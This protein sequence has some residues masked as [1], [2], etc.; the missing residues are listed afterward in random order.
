MVAALKGKGV[1]TAD[2]Q[3]SSLDVNS[4]TSDTGH[5]AGFSVSNQVTV[6][7]RDI[8]A[9]PAVLQAAIGAGANQAGGLRYFV[10]DPTASRRRGFD[11]AFQDARAKAEA[12]A[13]LSARRLGSVLCVTETQPSVDVDT[14]LSSLGYLATPK[15]E[16][17]SE[18]LTFRVTVVFELK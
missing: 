11:F 7:L 14:K 10:A 15:L 2:I 6:R 16:A 4:L 1:A 17:G 8:A 18:T 5:P 3:T 12:F 13:A 9:A